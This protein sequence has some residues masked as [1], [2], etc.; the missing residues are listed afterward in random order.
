MLPSHG[1]FHQAGQ[2]SRDHPEEDLHGSAALVKLQKL[3]GKHIHAIHRNILTFFDFDDAPWAVPAL[4]ETHAKRIQIRNYAACLGSSE[5][6][7]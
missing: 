5:T 2:V 4:G 1:G 7:R 6:L 3:K